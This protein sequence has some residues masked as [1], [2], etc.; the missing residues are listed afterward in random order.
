MCG[1]GYY[2]KKDGKCEKWVDPIVEPDKPITPVVEF[3]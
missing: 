1:K 2:M 3:S